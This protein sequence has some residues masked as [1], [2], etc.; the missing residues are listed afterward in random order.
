MGIIAGK[1]EEA[2]GGP[3]LV[4][5]NAG[6][7]ELKGSGRSPE[8]LNLKQLLDLH[9]ELFVKY[10]GHAGA[11]GFTIKTSNFNDLKIALQN[12][13]KDFKPDVTQLEADVEISEDELEEALEIEKMFQPSGEGNPPALFKSRMLIYFQIMENINI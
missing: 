11:A 1:L 8:S 12:N 10:G 4:F 13:L 6:T 5:T 9:P 2:Y 3:A 7:E